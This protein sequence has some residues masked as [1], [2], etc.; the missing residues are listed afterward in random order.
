[1]LLADSSSNIDHIEAC[2]WGNVQENFSG[3]SRHRIS[4]DGCGA[5][6]SRS[7]PD[8]QSWGDGEGDALLRQAPRRVVCSKGRASRALPL[9]VSVKP[10]DRVEQWSHNSPASTLP[11][12]AS[13]GFQE[14]A[15]VARAWCPYV[16]AG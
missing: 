11:V 1:M 3:L 8:V 15:A 5:T 16:A 12:R 14:G 10:R 9:V 4:P 7:S 2:S 6:P 13:E